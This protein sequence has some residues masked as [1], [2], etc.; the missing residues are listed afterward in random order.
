MRIHRILFACA[1]ILIPQLTNA[2]LLFP[3][4]FFGRVEGTLDFC[5]KAD[6]DSAAK[7]KEQGKTLVKDAS[8][9]ELTEARK[10]TEY[11]SAFEAVGKELA[12][13]PKAQALK[14]CKTLI[15]QKN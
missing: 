14:T 15:E 13:L 8:A 6:P 9:T 4:E 10:A 12:K 2:K 11:K 7:Y 3:N 5:G 1:A